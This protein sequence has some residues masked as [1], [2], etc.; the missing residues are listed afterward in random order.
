MKTTKPLSPDFGSS[1]RA[2]PLRQTR[3]NPPRS[4]TESSYPY[5]ARGSLAGLDGVSNHNGSRSSL[6]ERSSNHRV[7]C[8]CRY[9]DCRSRCPNCRYCHPNRRCRRW[10][11]NCTVYAHLRGKVNTHKLLFYLKLQRD[12]RSCSFSYRSP[13]NY[14]YLVS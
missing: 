14:Q 6:P 1:R 11:P 13:S 10:R 12:C 4:S 8:T 2:Q 3:T 5:G 9:S 7:Y